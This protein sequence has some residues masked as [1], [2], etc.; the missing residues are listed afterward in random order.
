MWSYRRWVR[1]SAVLAPPPLVMELMLLVLVMVPGGSTEQWYQPSSS[2]CLFSPVD[3]AVPTSVRC[4]LNGNSI[5]IKRVDLAPSIQE[6]YVTDANIIDVNDGAL[7]HLDD[8]KTA[9][10]SHSERL[11]LRSDSLAAS[12]NSSA[13]GSTSVTVDGV[14]DVTL[15]SEAFS[16]RRLGSIS[17]TVNGAQTCSVAGEAFPGGSSANQVLLSNI[18][19]LSM[20]RSSFAGAIEELQLRNVSS[21]YAC[22]ADTFSGE[23]G[24]LTLDSVTLNRISPGCFRS[25]YPW[26]SLEVRS[27]RLGAIPQRAFTGQVEEVRIENSQLED[28]APGG[29]ELRVNN[30]T[31]ENC[32]VDRLAGHALR[33]LAEDTITLSS[34]NV[35]VLE[36][37][38]LLG[39]RV[40]NDSVQPI[41]IQH[42]NVTEA[43][44]GS[45]RL[46]NSAGTI[47]SHIQLSEQCVCPVAAE[48]AARLA[49]GA[50]PQV[51]VTGEADEGLWSLQNVT[52][53]QMEAVRQTALAAHCWE[54]ETNSTSAMLAELVC[55]GCVVGDGAEDTPLL[56]CPAPLPAGGRRWMLWP[57]VFIAVLLVLVAG[58]GPLL[59]VKRCRPPGSAPSQEKG[60]VISH[61]GGLEAGDAAGDSPLKEVPRERHLSWRVVGEL[62]PEEGVEPTL[63]VA[64]PPPQPRH[65]SWRVIGE[66]EPEY[67]QYSNVTP[68]HPRHTVASTD[69]VRPPGLGTGPSWELDSTDRLLTTSDYGD[70]FQSLRSIPEPV[71]DPQTE[72]CI[73]VTSSPDRAVSGAEEEQDVFAETSP[74]G[75][76]TETGRRTLPIVRDSAQ[77]PSPAGGKSSAAESFHHLSVETRGNCPINGEMGTATNWPTANGKTSD[78]ISHNPVTEAAHLK[79][80]GSSENDT[81]CPQTGINSES[82]KVN[83]ATIE[84][85]RFADERAASLGSPRQDLAEEE[86]L[87]DDVEIAAQPTGASAKRRCSGELIDNVLYGRVF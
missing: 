9:E 23:I 48:R 37:A 14:R 49:L 85:R 76:L 67:P 59:M 11:L 73:N 77:E 55:R 84:D 28:V 5:T 54:G 51:N 8:L 34:C 4:H 80:N 62:E 29:F 20:D 41:T 68:A 25:S 82:S 16:G 53:T 60:A 19:N 63:P 12:A 83:H 52:D 22:L 69:S 27:S 74:T 33:V 36:D 26:Q 78:M 39:L 75:R 18:S 79:P 30:F 86:P 7:A 61:P 32:T 38:A 35:S 21:S 1:F 65:V 45:L 17:V 56:H 6:I 58:C 47:L 46:H 57:F 10:F 3:S 40:T 43:A 87:Y 50:P 24:Q 81:T 71:E 15:F 31:V 13:G 66:L 70:V 72:L 42:L 44:D 2:V 64:L